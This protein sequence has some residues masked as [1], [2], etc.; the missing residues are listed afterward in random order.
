MAVNEVVLAGIAVPADAEPY[1]SPHRY[2][3]A[4]VV[5]EDRIPFAVN[6]HPP[7]VVYV[8]ADDPTVEKALEKAGF[9]LKDDEEVKVNTEPAEEDTELEENDTVLLTK[10]VEGGK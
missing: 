10:N 4:D 2:L 9:E 5:A 7:P 6:V 1:L 8:P 3:E